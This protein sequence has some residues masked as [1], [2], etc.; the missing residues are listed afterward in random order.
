MCEKNWGREEARN[1]SRFM[2]RITSI[3]QDLKGDQL[4]VT[5]LAKNPPTQVVNNDWSLIY[6]EK[7]KKLIN[8]SSS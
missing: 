7:K 8:S 2:R 5:V 6:L 1:L 3:K 4:N